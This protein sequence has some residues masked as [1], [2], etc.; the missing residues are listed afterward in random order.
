MHPTTSSAPTL[1]PAA[2]VRLAPAAPALW[3][4]IDPGGRVIGHLAARIEETGT[5]Y[6]ARVLQ[7]Q[8]HTFRAVGE[9]WSAD[10]AVDCL[11]F[12]R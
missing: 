5:R 8:T 2:R 1:S 4:V 3:R 12:T 11:R 9:F 6:E 10:D 7:W